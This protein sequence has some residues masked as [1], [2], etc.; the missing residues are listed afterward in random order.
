M[1]LAEFVEGETVLLGAAPDDLSP[2]D[3]GPSEF[4]IN[5]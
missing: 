2:R 4:Y 3:F 5:Q 1:Q